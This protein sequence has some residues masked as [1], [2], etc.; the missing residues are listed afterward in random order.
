MS[1]WMTLFSV[2]C[3]SSITVTDTLYMTAFFN[4]FFK[5]EPFAAILI[6]HGTHGRSQKFVKVEIVKFEA[7]GRERR[8]GS[9]KWAAR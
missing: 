1:E 2:I 4:L 9:W 7:K 5:A 8:R 3:F 6:A